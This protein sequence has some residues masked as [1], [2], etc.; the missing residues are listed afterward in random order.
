MIDEMDRKLLRVLQAEGRITNQEL[1]SRCAISP[2]ACLDRMRRLKERGYI[3]G[4][5]AL[6]DP[7]KL[8]QSFLVFVEV[9]LDRTTG[10]VFRRFSAAVA[11]RP[12]ILEC[13]MVAGGFDYL[14]KL[15]LKDMAAYRKFLVDVLA[16]IPGVRETRTYAV[17]DEVKSTTALPI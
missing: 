7:E 8:D 16:E 13:H 2:S 15:R 5:A 3:S 4:Y 14:L 10:D 11:E 6:L 12:E 17:M 9:V 1:A